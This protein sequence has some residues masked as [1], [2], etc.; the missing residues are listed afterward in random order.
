MTD[1]TIAIEP[2]VVDRATAAKMLG[3]SLR[4]FQDHVLKDLKTV[5]VGT[6][7]LVP[8]ASIKAWVEDRTRRGEA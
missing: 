6:K 1:V 8:V 3:M 7:N 5:R 4:H 2:V